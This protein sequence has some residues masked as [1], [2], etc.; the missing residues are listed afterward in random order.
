M[1]L[2]PFLVAGARRVTD[3]RQ[4]LR[5][6][7]TVN[8]LRYRSESGAKH[9]LYIPAIEQVVTND[10]VPVVE[11]DEAGNVVYEIN[12]TTNQPK[13][14]SNGNPIP[15]YKKKVV[16]C[17][18]ICDIHEWTS[19]DGKYRATLCTKGLAPKN[20]KGELLGDGTCPFCDRRRDALDIC[21]YRINL[22]KDALRK[23]GVSEENIEGKIKTIS[24][25]YYEQLKVR[26][27][28]R[29]EYLLVAQFRTASK[30][31]RQPILGSDGLPEFDLKIQKLS[32]SRLEKY[33]TVAE[34]SGFSDI[35]NTE[36]LIQYGDS[37]DRM[38]AVSKS[39]ISVIMPQ[40]GFI[41]QY[42]GLLEK[43][44]Q[45]VSK[46]NLEDALC[47]T[48]PECAMMTTE[49]ARRETDELFEMWD[50]Y[51]KEL[52]TNPSA[53]YMEYI[54]APVQSN[55]AIGSG[56]PTPGVVI[57]GAPVME[58]ASN[59]SSTTNVIPQGPQIPGL[60]FSPAQMNAMFGGVNLGGNGGTGI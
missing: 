18:V 34:N 58:D 50:K 52:K 31:G 33:F 10:G 49:E 54:S 53:S 30:D 13:V 35:A 4:M 25:P 12:P 47:K 20:D 29:Y 1:S 7:A 3:S 55:P 22:E 24:K 21:Y 19:S 48:Y 9:H 41:A 57:P 28:K 40:G 43:I 59:K 51:K 26:E 36:L 60:G 16:T 15:K 6:L 14:D 2:N 56:I 32:L 44:N 23:Q 37:S 8:N 42:P 46:I 11:T 45:A 17:A 39:V 5:E 38:L 27:S